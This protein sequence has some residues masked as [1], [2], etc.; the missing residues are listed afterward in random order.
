MTRIRLKYVHEFIDSR[1]K[2]RCV[3]RR[4]GFPSVTLR[5]LPGSK[6]FMAAYQQALGAGRIE[7]GAS[8][9]LPGTLNAALAGYYTSLAFRE[10]ALGTQ[11][12]RRRILERLRVANGDRPMSGLR[13]ETVIDWMNKRTPSSA[14][15]LANALRGLFKFAMN[16]DPPFCKEDPTRGIPMPRVRTTERHTWTEEEIAR[17]EARHP[18]GTMARLAFDLF[19][20][21]GQRRGDVIRTGRQYIQNGVLTITQQKTKTRV[22]IPLHPKLQASID[23][24]PNVNMTFVIN[25]FGKPFTN[26]GFGKRMR[27]WCDEAGVPVECSAHGLRRAICRRLVEAGANAFDIMSITGHRDLKEVERYCRDFSRLQRARTAIERM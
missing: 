2:P 21:T 8:R 12:L 18:V 4:A 27:K 10:L 23:A 5:G 25:A 22:E 16:T 7:I 24:T 13:K 15:Q 6:E 26:G 1:G 19:L 3:F 11:K 17:C 20:Y 9:T 14:R